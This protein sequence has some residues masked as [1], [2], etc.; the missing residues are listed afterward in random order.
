[1]A[2]SFD[3]SHIRQILQ[4]VDIIEVVGNYVA[5]KRRGKEMIGLCP[6]HEDSRPSLN[7]SASKQIFKCFACGAGGDVI[8]FL[9]LRE[10]L[11]FPE[12]VQL[13]A[14]QAGVALPQRQGP[15]EQGF[16][17]TKL[18]ELNRWAAK[19]FRS[20]YED[21]QAGLRARRYVA[22][23]GISEQTAQRFGLGW[24]PAS[25]DALKQA[26]ERAGLTAAELV[27]VGL[28]IQREQGGYYDRFRERLIF[29]VIDAIGRVIGFGGRTLGDD[30]AKYLNSPES[31]LFEKS[32][33][34]YGIHAAKDTIVKERTAV[35]V[36]GYTDCLMAQ[37]FGITNV[38]AT[39]GTALTAEHAKVLSRYADRI[40]LVFDSDEAGR[41][42]AERA[43]E[44]FFDQRLEVRLVSLAEGQDPCD[45][46]LQQGKD[47]FVELIGRA[48]DAV[49]YKWQATLGELER[50][51]TV[52][53]RK[54]AAEEFLTFVAQA[55][56][57]RS[58]DAISEGFLINH[59]AK[60]VGSS[61]EQVHQRV[62]QLQRRFARTA[63]PKQAPTQAAILDIY[64]NAQREVLEVLL[65]RPELLPVASKVI[66]GPDDFA[67][68]TQRAIGQRLWQC[69]QSQQTSTLAELLA[70]IESVE[71][72]SI[73]TDMAAR[74]AGRANFEDTLAGALR[75]IQ[76]IRAERARQGVRELVSTAAE[77]YG[78]DAETAALL[79]Y[80]AKWQPDVRRLGT[81]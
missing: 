20:M 30:S 47:A 15:P 78:K 46:L 53:G 17:R 69:H 38:V 39:L 71:L 80:Q 7:V 31:E 74:G 44:V 5:L 50:A 61:A 54:R 73:I 24:A 32:R 37:Q 76:H 63:Q 66:K 36:E 40:V 13:L 68:E 72:S 1:V 57:R 79:E 27:R 2:L 56:G 14:K 22:G 41:K 42:A 26:A 62:R 65:N 49:A 33:A 75:Q 51:D 23:R 43:V 77:Q 70:G 4:A 35:V 55:L 45:F 12:A 48:T 64:V 19:F 67:D 3:E 8:K 34:L 11:S 6:F 58:I 59:V 10:R 25:W 9:M 29:P 81:S 52:S 28:L 16:D 60:L 21:E 18:E